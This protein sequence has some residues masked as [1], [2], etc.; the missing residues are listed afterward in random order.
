VIN[1]LSHAHSDTA[2]N[3]CAAIAGKARTY[4]ETKKQD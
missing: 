3:V 4:I 1:N 2:Y